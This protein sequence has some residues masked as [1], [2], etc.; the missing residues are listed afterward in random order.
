MLARKVAKHYQL[1]C[2]S[3]LEDGICLT[4]TERSRPPLSRLQDVPVVSDSDRAASASAEAAAQ[5]PGGVAEPPRVVKGVMRRNASSSN[6]LG[7]AGM[8]GG[9]GQAPQKT[10]EERE[11]EYERARERILGRTS[12]ADAAP[13]A[14]ASAST[15]GVV[16]APSF[17]NSAPAVPLNE[18]GAQGPDAGGQRTRT[19]G[20][21]ALLRDRE[22]D[23]ADPD[24][25]RGGYG[26]PM[27]PAY[28]AVPMPW[29]PGLMPGS[30]YPPGDF[31]PLGGAPVG[32][33]GVRWNGPPAQQYPQQVPRQ[34]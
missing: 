5:A 20:A 33:A 19:S 13:D 2:D 17:A 1:L 23:L 16:D 6:S 31:P 22:K 7:G 11:A 9:A 24:F 18:A 14:A 8:A 21:R 30:A 12:D 15:A 34:W 29:P 4:K 28:S 27:A 32:G 25:V 3:T 10:V 26:V